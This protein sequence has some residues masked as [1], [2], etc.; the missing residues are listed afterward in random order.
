MFIMWDA[1]QF[2]TDIDSCNESDE[3]LMETQTQTYDIPPYSIDHKMACLLT[4][5]Y[6]QS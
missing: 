6:V 1:L 3:Q 4:V 2:E 5:M